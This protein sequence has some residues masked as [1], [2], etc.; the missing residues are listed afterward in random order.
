M[1]KNGRRPLYLWLLG[2]FL[3]CFLPGLLTQD[4]ETFRLF[5]MVPILIVGVLIGWTGLLSPLQPRRNLFWLLLFLPSIVLDG[6]HLFGAYHRIWDQPSDWGFYTKSVGRYRAAHFLEDWR[7]RLGPGLL[8][9]DFVQGLPD[10]SLTVATYDYNAVLNP[11]LDPAQARWAAVLANVNYLPFLKNR[12]PEAS[13]YPLSKD[14]P[15]SDGGWMLFVFPLDGSNR[16]ALMKWRDAQRALEP[17]IDESLCYVMGQSF[18]KDIAL[19]ASLEPAF[20]GDPFLKS[21]YF[22]KKADLE[23]KEDL[24]KRTSGR[25]FSFQDPAIQSLEAGIREGYPTA[26]FYEH[27]GVL[28]WMDQDPE[29]QTIFS[30]GHPS[31]V[32]FDRCPKIFSG[33]NHGERLRDWTAA[34]RKKNIPEDPSLKFLKSSLIYFHLFLGIHL[35]L[36]YAPLDSPVKWGLGLPAL[37]AGFILY[38]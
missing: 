5:P 21:A 14:I 2:G 34:M 6:H 7:K 23:T 20:R 38:T 13:A 17:Y 9:L 19:L 3:F 10:Q 12:F 27:L 33:F 31:P 4:Q 25:I 26:H 22:E 29:G 24:M 15:G 36:S 35:F 28:Y 16:G 8:F 32:G 18:Q 30:K 1:V 11:R 37:A